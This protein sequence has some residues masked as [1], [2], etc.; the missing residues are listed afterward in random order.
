MSEEDKMVIRLCAVLL[1]ASLCLIAIFA[2]S[3]KRQGP[4]KTLGEPFATKVQ[5]AMASPTLPAPTKFTKT[6]GDPKRIGAT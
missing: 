3:N 6:V 2:V 5:P 1:G 4:Q